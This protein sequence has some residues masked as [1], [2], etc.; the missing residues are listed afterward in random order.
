MRI[1]L[2]PDELHTTTRPSSTA[3]WVTLGRALE[4]Y[5]PAERRIVSDE[6]APAF[7]STA[8][9]RLLSGLHATLPAVQRSERLHLAGLSA[10]ALCRHRFIDEQ[11]TRALE[12]GAE[13]L[14]ILGAG[15]DSRAYRFAAE[16]SGR[17]V[18]E[19]DLPPLSR[20]KAEIVATHPELFGHNTIRRIESD[21]QSQPLAEQLLG[22]GFAVGAQPVV[23]W[24]GVTP[25]LPREAV[26]ATLQTLREIC[27]AGSVLALDFWDGSLGSGALT[28]VRWAAVRGIRLVGE[29]ILFGVSTGQVSGL[30][31]DSG[32]ELSDVVG[33]EQLAQRYSTDGRTCDETLYVAAAVRR[34]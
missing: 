10:Y 20:R 13:Q 2:L 1:P 34:P 23:I 17:P 18:H 4:L 27:G 3:Q 22:S 28:P 14:L 7:L 16:L 29:P 9:R 15:Y 8:S 26:A 30:F 32:F 11:L 19:V 33:G 25:Y 31:A 24:E 12:S 5:R 6:Y 21:F